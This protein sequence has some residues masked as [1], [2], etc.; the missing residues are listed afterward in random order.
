MRPSKWSVFFALFCVLHFVRVD[1]SYAVTI[2][3]RDTS[4][5][6]SETI[7]SFADGR[8]ATLAE[9][10]SLTVTGLESFIV[11]YRSETGWQKVPVTPKRIIN[12][13]F[14]ENALRSELV[15]AAALMAAR[16]GKT[17]WL[18]DPP[19]ASPWHTRA[20]TAIVTAYLQTRGHEVVLHSGYLEGL[21]H[22]LREQSPD[23]ID[24][25]LNAIRD[26]RSDIKT[27]WMA[28]QIL[29]RVSLAV[30]NEDKF[31]VRRNNV[32]Y[33][34]KF[35]DGTVEMALQAIRERESNMWFRYMTQVV[36]P[37]ATRAKP[38]ICGISVGDERQFIQ[39]IILASLLKEALPS[40][41]IVL[42]GNFWSRV[43]GVFELPVFGKLFDRCCHALVYAEGFKPLEEM[44]ATLRPE[45]ASGTVYRKGNQLI[46][47]PRTEEPVD[48]DLLPTPVF[49]RSVRQWS[50][51]F[52]PGL[53]TISNCW[54][55]CKYCSIAA[56]SDTYLQ[57]PRFMK[58]ETVARHMMALG[59]THFEFFDE[60]L[61][62]PRQVKIGAI[63]RAN[64]YIADWNC[65]SLSSDE[66][67]KKEV[68]EAVAKA[69][70]GSIQIGLESMVPEALYAQR[71]PWNHPRNYQAITDNLAEFGTLVHI[72]IQ[73][74]LAEEK[75]TDGLRWLPFLADNKSVVSVKSGRNRHTKESPEEREARAF[76]GGDQ[77]G[78]LIKVMPDTK[79]LKLNRDF[80]YQR[81]GISGK[82]VNALRILLDEADR[83]REINRVTATRPWYPNRLGYSPQELW[84]MAKDLPPEP[85]TL[86]LDQAV[87]KTVGIIERELGQKVQ[88]AS[89][90]DVVEFARTL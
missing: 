52:V 50:P 41:L 19:V 48:F 24:W 80:V 90:D 44:A 76:E 6:H 51:H 25:A 31:M 39:A 34:S 42:G 70:C 53:Y 10:A 55:K 40:A 30:P 59:A 18:T 66:F 58:E 78:R 27:L 16:T 65:Y 68:C 77:A 36:V 54:H 43:T 7:V 1:I 63:L 22:V 45:T 69:G 84:A 14:E 5:R 81:D 61:H 29:E 56:G 60:T 32:H 38:H 47:N 73:L 8:I 20:G 35:Y 57:R 89:Y 71:K 9:G 46:V 88:L 3:G 83:R 11:N 79:P 82:G 33:I 64:G 86:Y 4:D 85:E 62:T 15:T 49:D 74:G 75:L 26:E 67:L 23:E 37:H 87:R 72:F 17:I 21:E 28:R 13:T 2:Q 12:I